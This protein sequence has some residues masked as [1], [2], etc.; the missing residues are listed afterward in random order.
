MGSAYIIGLAPVV[1]PTDEDMLA[2]SAAKLGVIPNATYHA[3]Y[4]MYGL[5]GTPVGKAGSSPD[6]GPYTDSIPYD[7]GK[8]A[9]NG[10]QFVVGS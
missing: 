9:Q 1:Q 4:T 8:I 6:S 2:F 3:I 10:L 5:A 7:L